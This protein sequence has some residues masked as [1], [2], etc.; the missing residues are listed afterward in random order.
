M[1]VWQVKAS[2]ALVMGVA[3]HW[4]VGGYHMGVVSQ[5]GCVCMCV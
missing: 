2:Q 5:G 1:W 3:N 4:R